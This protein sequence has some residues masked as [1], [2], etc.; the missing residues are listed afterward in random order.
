M[1][2][3]LTGI[4]AVLTLA[5]MGIPPALAETPLTPSSLKPCPFTPDEIGATLGVSVD[6]GQVADMAWPGG[7]D[8]GCL[9]VV[10]GSETVLSVRQTWDPGKA[11]QAALTKTGA[12]GKPSVELTYGRGNVRT[13]VL[14]H[15]GA[16]DEADMQPKLLKLK[17]VP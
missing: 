12:D 2:K 1:R 17:K 10:K 14:I 15:G 8:V 7:R 5:S 6:E 13:R 11:A 3:A 4:C 16:F 9:Y